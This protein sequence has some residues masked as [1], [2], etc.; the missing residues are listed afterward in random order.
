MSWRVPADGNDTLNFFLS[1]EKSVQGPTYAG[2]YRP[3][4]LHV[5]WTQLLDGLVEPSRED[6]G[7][8]VILHVCTIQHKL[9]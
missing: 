5:V 2:C 1:R 7:L 3:T 4:P 9:A 6:Y 8:F